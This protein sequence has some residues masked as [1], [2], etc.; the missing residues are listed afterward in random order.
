MKSSVRW[1]LLVLR[2]RL[3]RCAAR[4]CDLRRPSFCWRSC[5]QMR[6]VQ[7]PPTCGDTSASGNSSRA[8]AISSRMHCSLFVPSARPAVDRSRMVGS[9]DYSALLRCRRSGRPQADETYLHD[10]HD[11][12]ACACECRDRRFPDASILRPYRD[13]VHATS[14]DAAAAAAFHFCPA[15]RPGTYPGSE[16]LWATHDTMG[17]DRIICAVGKPARR[18]HRRYRRFGNLCCDHRRRDAG[19]QAKWSRACRLASL[20]SPRHWPR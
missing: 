9:G 15:R 10:D 8:K 12:P 18:L 13:C 3:A 5:W 1:T 20:R 2:P 14:T 17:R 11:H 7:R 6:C 4:C 19:R 16:H